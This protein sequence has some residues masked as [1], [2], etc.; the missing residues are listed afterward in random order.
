MMNKFLSKI[1][2]RNLLYNRKFTIT[3][4]IVLSVT[5]WFVIL[6]NRNPVRERTFS[7]LTAEVNISAAL[8]DMG[9][10]LSSDPSTQKFTVTVSGPNYVISTLKADDITL[11][12]SVNDITEAGKYRLA[13]AG[14]SNSSKSG[15]EF[16]AVSPQT[17]EVTVDNFDTKEYDVTPNL[18]GVGT[19]TNKDLI[20]ES[21]VISDASNRKIS[22]RG[23]RSVMQ[24]IATVEAYYEVNQ[25]LSSTQNFQSEIRILDTN[26]ALIYR[27]GSDNK[28]YDVN[29]K[30]VLNNYLEL[31]FTS[32]NV[33]QQ[34]SK[35]KT[36]KVVAQFAN[37]PSNLGKNGTL[38]NDDL[39]SCDYEKVVIQGTPDIVDSMSE[40]TLSPIDFKNISTSSNT[41]E[42]APILPDG[43][44]L[45]D[46]NDLEYFTVK[47]NTSGFKSNTYSIS[48]SKIEFV[49]VAA[50]L[51]ASVDSVPNITVC[52][53]KEFIDYWNAS[54]DNRSIV[55]DLEGYSTGSFNISNKTDYSVIMVKDADSAWVVGDYTIKV[56][57]K[58]K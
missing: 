49:N 41:F 33:T 21:P 23:P 43:V 31:D 16:V 27:Y 38:N 46:E 29:N 52:G 4:S 32:V 18:V 7:N 17:I 58:K 2:L 53:D 15:Y 40:L 22:I 3:I 48:T 51:K 26:G 28:I 55:I 36:L 42:V 24:K 25:I 30:V 11:V 39:W 10:D 54:P 5:I 19:P 37:I 14:A 13:V 57:L 8:K 20:A 35:E 9:L 34:I 12:A 1:N 6:I 50:G 47:I 56:S 45:S 44:T